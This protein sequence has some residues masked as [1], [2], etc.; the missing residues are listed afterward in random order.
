MILD[1]NTRL[2]INPS[3]VGSI[4]IYRKSRY[5]FNIDEIEYSEKSWF[6][7]EGW[8]LFPIFGRCIF[9]GKDLNQINSTIKAVIDCEAYLEIVDNVAKLYYNPHIE[10]SSSENRVMHTKYFNTVSELETYLTTQ[11]EL[12]RINWIEL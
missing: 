2:L 9:L 10:F 8:Y 4:R 7:K 1:K 3:N 11:P 6:S 5:K 12:N